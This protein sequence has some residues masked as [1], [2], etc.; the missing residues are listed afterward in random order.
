MTNRRKAQGSIRQTK[1][2]RKVV[3][4]GDRDSI[5]SRMEI[6]LLDV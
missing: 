1:D 3:G 5:A 2:V 6:N 4:C